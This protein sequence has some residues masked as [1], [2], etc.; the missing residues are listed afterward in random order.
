LLDSEYLRK[1]KELTIDGHLSAIM[2]KPASMCDVTELRNY[3][4]KDSLLEENNEFEM[5]K[6]EK[7]K[8]Q[9]IPSV[10]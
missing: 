7:F 6:L 5:L 4:P 9:N 2:R 3:Q 10:N 1:Q 8:F